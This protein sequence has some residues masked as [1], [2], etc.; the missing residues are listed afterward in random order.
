MSIKFNVFTGT[1]DIVGT[2]AAPPPSSSTVNR[3]FIFTAETV[4]IPDGSENVVTKEQ[5]VD[6]ILIVN[7]RNTVL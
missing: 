3:Y 2:S 1:F 6:G 5:T 4:T 7:G